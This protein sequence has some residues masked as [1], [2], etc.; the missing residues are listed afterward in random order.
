MGANR[1]FAPDDEIPGTPYVVLSRLGAGGYGTVYK[2]RHRMLSRKR[3]CV[4]ILNYDIQDRPDLAARLYRE[5]EVLAAMHHRNIVAVHDAGMT[6]ESR[7]RPY[8]VMEFHPGDTLRALLREAPRGTGVNTA[9]R[10]AVELAD[11]LDY[12]HTKHGI[13]HRDIKPENI[14]VD[15]A[16][17]NIEIPKLLD[18]G[19][20]HIIG[21]DPK[22]EGGGTPLYM[23]PEQILCR[24]P[25]PQTDLYSLGL[26]LYE[27][28]TG[29]VPWPDLKTA[30]EVSDAHLTRAP[31]P[32]GLSYVPAELEALVMAMLEKQPHHRPAS[33]LQVSIRLREVM[34]RLAHDALSEDNRTE[35][36]PIENHLLMTR[37]E[38]PTS[39]PVFL[40]GPGR[41]DDTPIDDDLPLDICADHLRGSTLP[42]AG[43]RTTR[44]GDHPDTRQTP[45]MTAAEAEFHARAAVTRTQRTPP[46]PE[47][48]K[49]VDPNAPEAPVSKR[50][51]DLEAQPTFELPSFLKASNPSTPPVSSS[52]PSRP[53]RRKEPHPALLALVLVLPT[54]LLGAGYLALRH[55]G[56]NPALLAPA[57]AS[58]S[59]DLAPV[60]RPMVLPPRD[61]EEPSATHEPPIAT[62]EPPPA[63]ARV[64][65]AGATKRV[66]RSAPAPRKPSG[67][68]DH[69]E[70]SVY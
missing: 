44:V 60:V 26:V 65:D 36:T 38:D 55:R 66:R 70:T 40:E 43:V 37:L 51:F 20:M 28:L 41:R 57:A 5:A 17:D 29:H 42:S 69:L 67:D 27:M 1:Q 46:P 22:N 58:T 24:A 21:L 6:A 30:S 23:A 3:A 15:A 9:V 45:I 53:T 7:A 33:A 10:L 35:P 48:E 39:P 61:T 2:V 68:I 13:V 34:K 54:A 59:V 8:F 50:W 64:A 11:G 25:T 12:A 63:V 19:V 16:A 56:E 47:T 18:F 52:P 62:V 14:Y 32:L 49:L 4:K 31:R